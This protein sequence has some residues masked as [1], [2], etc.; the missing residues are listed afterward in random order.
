F[1][2]SSYKVD[3]NNKTYPCYLLTRKG[4]DMVA[5]KMTGEKGVLFTAT[6]VTKFE[7]MENS[8]K[9]AIKDSYMI[10]DPIARAKAWIIEAEEKQ[11]LTLQ[12]EAQHPKVI[13]A[14]S[15]AVSNTSILIGELAKI[16]KGNG[17]DIGEK[18]FFEWLRNNKYLISRKGTDYNAPTQKSM[19]LG[20]FK[21]KETV[22]THSDGHITINKTTKVTG[23]GQIYFVNKFKGEVME[24]CLS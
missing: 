5:N 2:K 19:D 12:L 4:C 21:V 14:D 6:Y 15:V 17:V 10:A 3:G 9:I 13:F 22:V 24:I 16:I 18:R 20:I 11:S 8:L 23:K 7:E 1:I